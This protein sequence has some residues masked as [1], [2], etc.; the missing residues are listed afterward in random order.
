[1]NK[2]RKQLIALMLVFAIPTIASWF[3]IYNPEFLPNARS[4]KGQLIQPVISIDNL[5]FRNIDDKTLASVAQYK[6]YWTIIVVAGNHCDDV[7]KRKIHDMRQVRKALEEDYISI[8]RLVLISS[9]SVDMNLEH[10]IKPYH[11]TD[12]MSQNKS[13]SDKIIKQLGDGK[14]ITNYTFI[15]DPMQNVM[16][17]YAPEQ[18]PKDLLSDLRHLLKINKW[19]AG[20]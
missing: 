20:H 14:N 18:S 3:F 1:M 11:G 13:L 4:N 5:K 6:G 10:Y 12:V 9:D 17:R 7:C 16:M 8:K 15:M 19:G 2:S